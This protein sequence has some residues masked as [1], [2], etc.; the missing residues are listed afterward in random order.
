MIHEEIH[1][2]PI[3]VRVELV[4][5]SGSIPHRNHTFP[6][7]F[8][9]KV[10]WTD[11][12]DTLYTFTYVREGAHRVV[13]ANDDRNW[14]VKAE[15]LSDSRKNHN[16]EEWDN[17]GKVPALRSVVP[18]ARGYAE[19]KFGDACFSLLFVDRIGFTFAE[20]MCRLASQNLTAVSLGIGV[21][22]K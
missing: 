4:Q 16:K 7:H 22:G 14:V 9:C 13:Y 10:F 6:K 8:Q 12:T 21:V 1:V 17:F 5:F 18:C 11:G 20:I 2:A 15:Y 3:L 19:S